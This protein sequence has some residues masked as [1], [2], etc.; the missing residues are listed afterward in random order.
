MGRVEEV[1]ARRVVVAH[2]R[3]VDLLL[4]IVAVLGWCVAP[5]CSPPLTHFACPYAPV[6]ERVCK[7]ED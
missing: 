1:L 5:F 7:T 3:G 4:G 2:E 6:F